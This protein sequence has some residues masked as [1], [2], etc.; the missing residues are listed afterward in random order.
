MNHRN[1]KS[2]T[3]AALA[4]LLLHFGFTALHTM[5]GLPAPAFVKSWSRAYMTPMFHQ[6]WMLFAPD[7]KTFNAQLHYR[8]PE[9]G[10]WSEW[11]T[12]DDLHPV[13]DHRRLFYVS[14]K[15]ALKLVNTMNSKEYGVYYVNDQPQFDKVMRTADYQR[16]LYMAYKEHEWLTSQ[17]ADSLQLRLD[18]RFIPDPQ[19]GESE[20]DDLTFTFPVEAIHDYRNAQ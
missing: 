5:P 11:K 4:V 20:Y 13:T 6:G 9:N 12:T 19:T 1:T 3:V 8:V 17:R 7:V 18:V 16:A 2:L 14:R 15:V 10:Q